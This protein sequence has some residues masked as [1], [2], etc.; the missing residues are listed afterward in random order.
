[1][2]CCRHPKIPILTPKIHCRRIT[3]NFFPY[4]FSVKGAIIMDI[5]IFENIKSG[6]TLD[7]NMI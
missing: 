6:I 7:M 5:A 2:F 1:M 4:L 3:T